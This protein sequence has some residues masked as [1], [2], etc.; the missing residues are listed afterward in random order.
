MTCFKSVLA[1]LLDTAPRDVTM[2]TNGVNKNLRVVT[3]DV[4]LFARF[5][6]S[7]LHSKGDL[8]HEVELIHAL[9]AAGVPAVSR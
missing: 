7:S 1:G 3:D 2:V 4:D 9:K 8:E 6:P 5:S